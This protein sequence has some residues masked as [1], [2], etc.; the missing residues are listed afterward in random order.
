M[1]KMKEAEQKS[2][3]ERAGKA[4]ISKVNGK[5]N[6]KLNVAARTASKKAAGK[7]KEP[8]SQ[9]ADSQAA[10]SPA[11]SQELAS[12]IEIGSSNEFSVPEEW[13]DL[14]YNNLEEW[15]TM[16]AAQ[17]QKIDYDVNRLRKEYC[18]Y[19]LKT[20]LPSTLL[21][22]YEDI[23]ASRVGK[24]K[25]SKYMTTAVLSAASAV[26]DDHETIDLI[27]SV[28]A[29]SSYCSLG[30]HRLLTHLIA[31]VKKDILAESAPPVVAPTGVRKGAGNKKTAVTV[32][33][34]E[35]RQ[36]KNKPTKQTSIPQSRPRQY[37]PGLCLD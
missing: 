27:T 20:L 33:P 4:A 13:E 32:V 23:Q 9:P 37:I 30:K 2:N 34:A 28:C 6:G 17:K 26:N 10:P 1:A 22:K 7:R 31:G 35:N 25:L 36:Q 16:T 12:A 11:V 5:P 3:K 15:D 18:E 19:V 8:V 21:V 29:R 14:L 24:N